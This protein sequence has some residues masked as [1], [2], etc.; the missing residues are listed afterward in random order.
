[1]LHL[2]DSPDAEGATVDTEWLWGEVSPYMA[3]ILHK[4]EVP[5]EDAEDIVV[6][7][8]VR[9]LERRGEIRDPVSWLIATVRFEVLAY[10]RAKRVRVVEQLD[11]ELA[12]RLAAPPSARDPVLACKLDRCLGELSDRCRQVIHE[13]YT[14]GLEP[15]ELAPRLGYTT[16]GVRK[17]MRTCLTR[18]AEQLS[19]QGA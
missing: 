9:L 14:L 8:F 3:G 19:K 11:E 16:R 13:R 1:M 18:L 7:T 10:W 2:P 15:I 5:A 17:L 4:A 6:E 12:A